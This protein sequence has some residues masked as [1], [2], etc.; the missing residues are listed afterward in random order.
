MNQ[1]ASALPVAEVDAAVRAA[2]MKNSFLRGKVRGSSDTVLQIAIIHYG[3]GRK[4]RVQEADPIVAAEIWV[5]LDLK[6]GATT[7][8]HIG[9]FSG[10]SQSSIPISQVATDPAAA[11]LAYREAAASLQDLLTT[12]FTTRYGE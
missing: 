4:N 2:V 10:M 7:V 11:T 12:I 5:S 3:L 8:L 9:N 6:R 1:N